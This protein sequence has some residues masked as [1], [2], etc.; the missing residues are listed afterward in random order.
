MRLGFGAS[1]SVSRGMVTECF[2][3]DAVRNARI[4][5]NRQSFPGRSFRNHQTSEAGCADRSG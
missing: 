1:R 3:A 2:S 5:R 4:R